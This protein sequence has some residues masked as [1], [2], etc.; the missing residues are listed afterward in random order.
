MAPPMVITV[1]HVRLVPSSSNPDPAKS[2]PR[3][4][5]SRRNSLLYWS[6]IRHA[7]FSVHRTGTEFQRVRQTAP[8][9]RSAAV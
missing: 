8:H 5:L 9:G 7:L 4:S 1:G 6:A 2:V 3:S